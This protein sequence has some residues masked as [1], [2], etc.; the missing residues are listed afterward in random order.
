MTKNQCP[1]SATRDGL[2]GDSTAR[3]IANLR[4]LLASARLPDA[5]RAQAIGLLD[6]LEKDFQASALD[7]AAALGAEV[8]RD[9]QRFDDALI[10]AEQKGYARGLRLG[11]EHVFGDVQ[12]IVHAAAAKLSDDLS[13]IRKAFRDQNR[14]T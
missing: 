12:D 13:A 2:V 7:A 4:A 14:G 11:A 6:G 1:G 8:Y 10:A 9:K 3:K 5:K